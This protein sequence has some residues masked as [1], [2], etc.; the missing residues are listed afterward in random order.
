MLSE[1]ARRATPKRVRV[2]HFLRQN[3]VALMSS[4]G[5]NLR[6]VVEMFARLATRV[7]AT[8]SSSQVQCFLEKSQQLLSTHESPHERDTAMIALARS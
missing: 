3:P 1:R 7:V 4:S 8:L 6:R 5:R 2:A